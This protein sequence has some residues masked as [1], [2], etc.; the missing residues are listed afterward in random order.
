MAEDIAPTPDEF[1]AAL[2]ELLGSFEQDRALNNAGAAPK[3]DPIPNPKRSWV[4]E[5]GAGGYGM[6]YMPPMVENRLGGAELRSGTGAAPEVDAFMEATGLPLRYGPALDMAYS[7]GSAG[8]R[9]V[10]RAQGA[11]GAAADDPS[12][13]NVTNA[14]FQTGM[15]ALRPSIAL[16]TLGAGYVGAAAQDMGLLGGTSEAEA[17]TKLTRDQRRALE[18]EKQKKELD[19][20]IQQRAGD[21]QAKREREAA[22][23]KME[24]DLL[25]SKKGN[26][27]AEYD[28]QVAESEAAYKQEMARNRRFSDTSVGQLYDATGGWA[29]AA[30]GFVGAKLSRLATGPGKTMTGQ[31]T[32]DYVLP[33]TTGTI[34]GMITPNAPLY[35]NSQQ[36]EPDNPKKRAYE[37]RAELLP[38]THPRRDEFMEYAR[39]LPNENPIRAAALAEF[40]DPEKTKQ[41]LLMGGVEGF[42]GG[43]LGSDAVRAVARGAKAAA[44][45]LWGP[46]GAQTTAVPPGV[47]V[48]GTPAGRNALAAPAGAPQIAGPT[49]PGTLAAGGQPLPQPQL[50]APAAPAN[51]PASVVTRVKGK[52]GNYTLH[53]EKG[54]FTGDPRKKP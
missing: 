8:P 25:A 9:Q 23:A 27:Q 26:E 10:Q 45:R 47:V 18:I 24:R 5:V 35:Y 43:L 30:M 31:I 7:V 49:P 36:T 17:Q 42:A 52:D 20:A 21:A 15:A 44:N 28:R 16:G 29:P 34:A 3:R 40:S 37:A 22:D 38:P 51:P 41:R 19:A 2:T 1:E 33:V 48:A 50:P 4:P 14:G 11:I 53:N 39:S 13:A 32:K 54:H 6:P 46:E 12:L